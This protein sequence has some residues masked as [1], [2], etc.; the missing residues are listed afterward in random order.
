MNNPMIIEKSDNRSVHASP[1]EFGNIGIEEITA[2]AEQ[3]LSNIAEAGESKGLFTVKT[4][5]RWIEQAKT[6]PI[7]KMLFGE[8]WF[9]G[10]LCILFADSNVG[11]SI[12]AVQIG[13]SISKGMHIGG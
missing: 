7:P 2:E 12:L 11:K 4:A 9:E 6:R 3:L 1:I 10:E 13:D 5:D 8:F